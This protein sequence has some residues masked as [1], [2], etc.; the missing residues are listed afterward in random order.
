MS[1]LSTSMGKL[2]AQGSGKLPSQTIINPRDN[3][4]KISLRSGKELEGPIQKPSKEIPKD[5]V[6]SK[7]ENNRTIDS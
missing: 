1:Q 4:S 3:T 2:E 6:E 7:A 5:K